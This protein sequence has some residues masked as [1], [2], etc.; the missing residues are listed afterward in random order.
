MNSKCVS[1]NAKWLKLKSQS[2]IVFECFE[3][4]WYR[5]TAVYTP[6]LQTLQM[7]GVKNFCFSLKMFS[8]IF[9]HRWYVE[10]LHQMKLVKNTQRS[11]CDK[12]HNTWGKCKA[13]VF[14]RM[15][16]S[17]LFTW[18]RC[19]ILV[20]LHI[21]CEVQKCV[22]SY[23]WLGHSLRVPRP[24]LSNCRGR[25]FHLSKIRANRA[26]IQ[27]CQSQPVRRS[28]VCNLMH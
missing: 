11:W 23:K 1:I 22:K 4:Y 6:F 18:I 15:I 16:V 3:R 9:T 20:N 21:Y 26:Q 28:T 24:T 19:C 7:R 8:Q 25:N 10:Y 13:Q 2:L 12:S 5:A 27:R 14:A 17:I